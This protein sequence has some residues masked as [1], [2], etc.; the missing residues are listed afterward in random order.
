MEKL[1]SNNISVKLTDFNPNQF[2]KI[3]K[4]AQM[5]YLQVVMTDYIKPLM[6][7]EQKENEKEKEPDKKPGSPKGM[8]DFDYINSRPSSYMEAQRYFDK[9]YCSTKAIIKIIE[10]ELADNFKNQKFLDNRLNDIEKQICKRK[11]IYELC[12]ELY[13]DEATEVEKYDKKMEKYNKTIN[14]HEEVL[15][16]WQ[17]LINDVRKLPSEWN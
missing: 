12:K 14:H 9:V 1:Q 2:V 16:S 8:G 3:T 13:Q 15:A 11:E 17:C 6:Y 7:V 10:T 5:K 4:S